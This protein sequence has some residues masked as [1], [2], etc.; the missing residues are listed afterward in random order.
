MTKVVIARGAGESYENNLPLEMLRR[1]ER[2]NIGAVSYNII[3]LQYPASIGPV[4]STPDPVDFREGLRESVALGVKELLNL[5]RSYPK[6]DFI[7]IGYSLGAMV[8]SE[9][10]SEYPL[11]VRRVKKVIL[12][13]NPHAPLENG[14]VG[15]A[16][17]KKIADRSNIVEIRNW[18]DMICSVVNDS[19]LMRLPNLVAFLTGG[20]RDRNRLF[21]E[22]INSHFSFIPTAY[23]YYQITGYLNRTS[24]EQ[25]YLKYGRFQR[26][27]NE[28]MAT[29]VV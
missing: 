9:F 19:V 17:P 21:W 13:A 1:F 29:V 11:L 26:M 18:D 3:S 24:H 23:D 6:E 14:R 27:F 4:N 2:N 7:F 10:L 16:G 5:Y 15:I 8:L 12:I 28:A 25:D 20:V 22:I